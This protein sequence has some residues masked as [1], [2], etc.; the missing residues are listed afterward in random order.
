MPIANAISK[1][2]YILLMGTDLEGGKGGE[3]DAEG[4]RGVIGAKCVGEGR[5]EGCFVSQVGL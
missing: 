3:L 5:V 4:G 1:G 2:P